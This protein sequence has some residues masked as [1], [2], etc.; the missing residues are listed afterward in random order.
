[1][2]V[3][4]LLHELLRHLVFKCVIDC[5]MIAF[6]R[7]KEIINARMGKTVVF[8]PNDRRLENRNGTWGL[9]AFAFFDVAL[10]QIVRSILFYSIF[11][12]FP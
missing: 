1:M 5:D 12:Q 7:A 8:P 9:L 2:A 4:I 3:P 10:F 11:L 6:C